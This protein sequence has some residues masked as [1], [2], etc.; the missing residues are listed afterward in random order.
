MKRKQVRIN[1]I[2][3]NRGEP[4]VT[5]DAADLMPLFDRIQVGTLVW[6]DAQG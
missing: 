4:M 1:D 6:I 5:L 2:S 3:K